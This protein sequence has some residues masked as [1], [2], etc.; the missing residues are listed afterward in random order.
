MGVDGGVAY[1]NVQIRQL[2]RTM[3]AELIAMW[4]RNSTENVAADW[5]SV[6]SY[7]SQGVSSGTPVTWQ[8]YIDI[9]AR[10]AGI[11]DVKSRGNPIMHELV[12]TRGPALV[13][14]TSVNP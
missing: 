10:D 1:T 6:V 5:A 12:G 11:G 8:F 3:E 13:I 14:A 4:P 7:A 9:S 2:I